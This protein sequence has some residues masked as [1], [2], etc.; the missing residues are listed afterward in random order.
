[1]AQ[2]AG[3]RSERIA[4]AVGPAFPMPTARVAVAYSG[5]RDST[6]LLHATVHAAAAQGLQVVA[7]HVHHGLSPEADA[8]LAHCAQQCRRWAARG[9]PLRFDHR[10]L[11]GRPTA[12]ES[13]EAWAR[14]GRYAALREMAEAHH[15]PLVLLAHHRQDQAETL[16]LQAL[17]GA[18]V[19]GLA[20][21]PREV[22]RDGLHWV[23]PWL[24]LSPGGISAYVRRFRLRHIDDD[25]N[26]DRRFAR[27]RLRLDVWPAFGG[28]FPGAE[29]ALAAAAAWA[30]EA[31]DCAEALAAIDLAGVADAR[32][33]DLAAWAALSPARRSNALRAW[34]KAHTG[35]GAS[36]AN[37]K[38]LLVELPA[39]GPARW[40][41][42][43]FELRRYRGRLTCSR[44]AGVARPE[45]A[46]DTPLCITG[47]GTY[48]VPGWSGRLRVG[49]TDRGGAALSDLSDLHLAERRGGERFQAAPGRPP[50]SLKKQ[51]QGAA[52]PA[53]QRAAPLFYSG[54][55]LLF[56]PGLGIDARAR[57]ADGE[58]Q[59]TLEWIP[60]PG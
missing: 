3:S 22:E 36:A 1:M 34:L 14:S 25:S 49:L 29:A 52:V 17:R 47:A 39:P 37:V 44:E 7:L 16:L 48:A 50:R 59:A 26:E 60:G 6:A 38:R 10:R 20:A 23:R 13:V 5:G 40:L 18:G 57:A 28:A 31:R 53:W 8:W 32:G 27:N 42:E 46:A 19:A 35:A 43:G 15:A 2:A 51:F 21:M 24:G 30:A 41:L 4:P 55:Q 33:L 9:L 54:E 12:G 11:Q 56:V 58:P 45:Q